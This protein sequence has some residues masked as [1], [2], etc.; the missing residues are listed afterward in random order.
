MYTY[1]S[2]LTIFIDEKVTGKPS[3]DNL[4]PI[5]VSG[6]EDLSSIDSD[7]DKCSDE[8]SEGSRPIAPEVDLEK[9]FCKHRLPF[10]WL[11]QYYSE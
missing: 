6:R 4:Q 7:S 9:G 2:K 1:V 8:C 11:I 10:V 5:V 3:V